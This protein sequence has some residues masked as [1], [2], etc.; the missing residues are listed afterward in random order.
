MSC[1]EALVTGGKIK[2]SNQGPFL[3]ANQGIKVTTKLQNQWIKNAWLQ[4]SIL[5]TNQKP[6]ISQ[7]NALTCVIT[8]YVSK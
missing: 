1:V 7:L 6:S 3:R 5:F 2:S 8:E 4:L